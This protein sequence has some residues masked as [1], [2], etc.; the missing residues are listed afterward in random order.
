ME[1]SF[2]KRCVASYCCVTLPWK[3]PC[4]ISGSSSSWCCE[5][6]AAI[7]S[8]R[9]PLACE[10]HA[11]PTLPAAFLV[12]SST[13]KPAIPAP[14]ATVERFFCRFSSRL[15]C[16]TAIMLSSR[17]RRASSASMP[18]LYSFLRASGRIILAGFRA[19]KS[20]GGL[21]RARCGG[22]RWG[23]GAAGCCGGSDGGEQ[24]SSW[25]SVRLNSRALRHART[26]RPRPLEN[27]T[28]H[29]PSPSRPVTHTCRCLQG[30]HGPA[31]PLAPLNPGRFRTQLG[32]GS[33]AQVAA[34]PTSTAKRWQP[35]FAGSNPVRTTPLT[36]I[37][38]PNTLPL[39]PRYLALL[40]DQAKPR[41]DTSPSQGLQRM[42]MLLCMPVACGAVD[43]RLRCGAV[44]GASPCSCA[45]SVLSRP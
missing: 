8:S 35:Q 30:A 12:L 20:T 36:L 43:R 27:C 32:V 37:Q 33:A 42:S 28:R 11:P 26:R 9:S 31:T 34:T 10:P 24:L 2:L 29:E 1:R 44:L 39:F 4:T 22:R 5:G 23:C 17:F 16:R 45:K 19:G 6:G 3:T 41:E 38:P 18:F 15:L 14:G 21:L 7:F 25:A 40:M 13:P